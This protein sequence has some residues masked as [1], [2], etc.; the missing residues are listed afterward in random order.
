MGQRNPKSIT[1]PYGAGIQLVVRGLCRE[2][3]ADRLVK[4]ELFAVLQRVCNA[5]C[6]RMCAF[7]RSIQRVCMSPRGPPL[8][9]AISDCETQRGI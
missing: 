4:G 1:Y 8:E 2:K 6:G 5:W 3:P 7:K 9:C